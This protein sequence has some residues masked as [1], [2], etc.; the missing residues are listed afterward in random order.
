MLA[1]QA[2][3]RLLRHFLKRSVYDVRMVPTNGMNYVVIKN[4]QKAILNAHPGR[5]QNVKHKKTLVLMH[6]YGAGLGFFYG[7]ILPCW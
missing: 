5:V 6:G 3:D 4:K 7:K 2:Q 1:L